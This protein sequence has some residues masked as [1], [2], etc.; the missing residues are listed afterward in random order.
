M[1]SDMPTRICPSCQKQWPLTARLCTCG[2]VFPP[3]VG[4]ESNIC[5]QCGT[6]FQPG[7]AF[8]VCGFNLSNQFLPPSTGIPF[9][10]PF[11]SSSYMGPLTPTPDVLNELARR[12]RESNRAFNM[13]IVVGIFIF[14][15][16][17]VSYLEYN[18][19]R[20]IRN[21][22]AQMGVNILWWESMYRAKG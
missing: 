22:I 19:M 1:T 13:T 6:T 5:P 4:L 8:C 16:W 10:S 7:A 14:P 18:K 9:S 17:V 21:Q 11:S 15:V 3:P 2:Y 12:H 20:E